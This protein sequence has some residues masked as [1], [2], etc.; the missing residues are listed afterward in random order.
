MWMLV[1]VVVVKIFRVSIGAD[2]AVFFVTLWFRRFTSGPGSWGSR[3][4]VAFPCRLLR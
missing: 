3:K 1:V 2:V 4:V